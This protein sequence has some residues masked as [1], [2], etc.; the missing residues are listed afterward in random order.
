MSKPKSNGKAKVNL[1]LDDSVNVSSQLNQSE[2]KGLLLDK[3][4]KGVTGY[5]EQNEIHPEELDSHLKM[6]EKQLYEAGV[7]DDDP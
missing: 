4:G 7:K 6:I 1:G 5:T 2:N 3:E